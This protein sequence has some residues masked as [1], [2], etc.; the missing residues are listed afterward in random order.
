MEGAGGEVRGGG[1]RM[2]EGAAEK[3]LARA[4]MLVRGELKCTGEEARGRQSGVG[5]RKGE[6][7]VERCYL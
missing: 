4:L 7:D 3:A 5:G 1:R 6:G 2:S